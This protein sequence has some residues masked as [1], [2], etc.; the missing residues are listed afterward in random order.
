MLTLADT[1]VEKSI[2]VG[3][4]T[5]RSHKTI[6]ATSKQQTQCISPWA[7]VTV[8]Y[9][10]VWLSITFLERGQ[11]IHTHTTHTHNTHTHTHTYRH[12]RLWDWIDY[13]SIFRVKNEVSVA[14]IASIILSI[15]R[16]K[17]IDYRFRF[18]E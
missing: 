9:F 3:I 6:M 4:T 7:C 8:S 13:L 15:F 12:R 18:L 10:P 16:V 14:K 5:R 1:S 17:T 2:R 11:N